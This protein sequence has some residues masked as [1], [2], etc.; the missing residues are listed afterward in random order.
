MT[1]FQA[2]LEELTKTALLERLVRL[3]ATPIQGTPKLLMRSRSPG[4]LKALQEGVSAGW[5][6]RVTDPLMRAA[7]GPISRLPAGKLQ[8]GARWVAHQVA[9]DPVGMTATQL[10]PIPGATAAYSGLKRGLER[11]IDYA[12][13]L[14]G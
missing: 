3:A 12:A 7:E 11:A 1:P 14:A 2:C 10:L 5:N 8:S 6:R 9:K 13:P 4:E